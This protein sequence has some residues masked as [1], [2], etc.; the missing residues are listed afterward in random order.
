LTCELA[1][2]E[3]RALPAD[4]QSTWTTFK[5]APIAADTIFLGGFD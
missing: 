5:L 3:G 4:D 2:A 1:Q